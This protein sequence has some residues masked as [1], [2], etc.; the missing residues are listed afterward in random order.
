MT[1]ASGATGTRAALLQAAAE[2]MVEVGFDAMT[3]A[4]LA[5]RAGLAEGTLYRHFP[6]KEAITEAVFEGAWRSNLQEIEAALPPVDQPGAR[7]RAFLP[8]AMAV[9]A[10]DPVRSQ[11]CNQCHMHWIQQKRLAELPPGPSDFVHLLESTLRAAQD[12]GEARKDFDPFF[13]ANF[14]FHAG[15]DLF[16]R[17]VNPPSPSCIPR[18]SPEAFM[19]AWNTFLDPCLFLEPR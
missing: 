9:L 15:G 19:E 16:E 1:P 14:L 10:A 18:Y 11:I 5:R 8:V 6:G 3:T 12:A 4:A 17:F 7:L 2:L 13:V